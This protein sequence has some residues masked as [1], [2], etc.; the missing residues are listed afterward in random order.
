M[1]K[2]Y[3]GYGNADPEKWLSKNK[4]HHLNFL[5]C[6]WVLGRECDPEH[7]SAQIQKAPYHVHVIYVAKPMN[8]RAD[9]FPCFVKLM[10]VAEEESQRKND[11][12][13]E[14]NM[15]AVFARGRS[16]DKHVFIVLH[17]NFIARGCYDER[18]TRSRGAGC[19]LCLGIGIIDV[20]PH[21]SA[22]QQMVQDD[23]TTLAHWSLKNNHDFVIANLTPH[24]DSELWSL[25]AKLSNAIDDTPVCQPLHAK[26]PLAV[27]AEDEVQRAMYPT[28]LFLYAEVINIK[29]PNSQRTLPEDFNLVEL[30]AN[31]IGDSLAPTW[32]VNKQPN[33]EITLLGNIIVKP[34]SWEDWFNDCFQRWLRMG[35]AS[36]GRKMVIDP[37]AVAVVVSLA[38][39]ATHRP[40]ATSPPQQ[41]RELPSV[42]KAMHVETTAK[43]K[44]TSI[45]TRLASQATAKTKAQAKARARAKK[46]MPKAKANTNLRDKPNTRRVVK[47]KITREAN[48][49]HIHHAAHRQASVAERV[50]RMALVPKAKNLSE[51]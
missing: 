28:L 6:A 33:Y 13:S 3:R 5:F 15:K 9:E 34:I 37:P 48:T 25:V 45:K 21:P 41:M 49:R 26:L 32:K 46:T 1:K 11:Y 22:D 30:R 19:G 36:G 31:L 4:I 20:I 16:R 10:S 44:A 23:A 43:A 7:M 39:A 38:V 51:M 27:A 42:V 12:V 40:V 29:R 17:R 18:C 50:E 14:H 24:F 35:W 8:S 47:T 2:I